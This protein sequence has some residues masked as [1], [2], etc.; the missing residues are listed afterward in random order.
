MLIKSRILNFGWQLYRL[1][2]LGGAGLYDFFLNCSSLYINLGSYNIIVESSVN[3]MMFQYNLYKTQ[4]TYLMFM[5]Y[6]YN[7]YIM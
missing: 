4:C 1:H 5:R 6:L 2:I 7:K 3:E